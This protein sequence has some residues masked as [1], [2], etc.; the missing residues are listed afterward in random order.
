MMLL[1]AASDAVAQDRRTPPSEC[2]ERLEPPDPAIPAAPPPPRVRRPRL[3]VIPP[4]PNRIHDANFIEVARAQASEAAF[5]R[6]LPR[7]LRAIERCH[8]ALLRTEPGLEGGVS[9]TVTVEPNGALGA[10][11]DRIE[12][13]DERLA[14]CTRTGLV[15]ARVSPRHAGLLVPVTLGLCARDRAVCFAG[16]LPGDGETTRA[17]D[18]HVRARLPM[19]EA[20]YR[21]LRR[22]RRDVTG[23]LRVFVSVDPSGRIAGLG[24]DGSTFPD[25]ETA[26]VALEVFGALSGG[27]V[28][29]PP[30]SRTSVAA[31]FA[32]FRR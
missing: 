31:P 13:S 8:G 25:P 4:D 24:L 5:L 6:E 30:A 22:R 12:A 26:S 20:A 29:P 9:F 27:C 21:A 18:A 7:A 3:V 11:D 17:L 28:R 1:T 15:G 14:E 10:E 32:L 19:I 2:V 16:L 23:P